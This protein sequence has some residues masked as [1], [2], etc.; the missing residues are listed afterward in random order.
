MPTTTTLLHSVILILHQRGWA[1]FFHGGVAVAQILRT[2]VFRA[3]LTRSFVAVD[4]LDSNN[5]SI[6][7]PETEAIRHSRKQD[8][9]VRHGIIFLITFTYGNHDNHHSPE[10]EG[11]PE[12]AKSQMLSSQARER[13]TWQQICCCEL[14][15]GRGKSVVCEAVIRGEIMNKVLKT[16]AAAFVELKMLKN[17]TGSL[18]LQAL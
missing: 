3:K 9:M 7:D 12:D 10:Q 17:L 5:Q 14:I 11:T 8:L 15:E 1:L 18:L 16:S 2:K 4:E 13:W 6:T